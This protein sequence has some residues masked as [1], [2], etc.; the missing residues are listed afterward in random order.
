[1]QRSSEL[2]VQALER[3]CAVPVTESSTMMWRALCGLGTHDLSAMRE[4]LGMPTKVLGAHRG[5]PFWK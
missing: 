2:V 5:I 4:V 1:M 3:E